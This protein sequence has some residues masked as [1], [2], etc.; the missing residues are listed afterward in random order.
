MMHPFFFATVAVATDLAV[1]WSDC[2]DSSFKAKINDV[3]PKTITMGGTSTITG[4]GTLGEEVTDQVNFDM[5]MEV[6]FEDCKGVA[7]T[8]G[9]CNFPLNM[10]SIEFVGLASPIKA[11]E[12]PINVNLYISR[13]LPA[14]LMETTTQVTA[15][16]K[17][18]GNKIFCLNVY[19]KKSAKSHLGVGILDVT[20]SDCGDADTKS[21]VHSLTPPELK[22][23]ATQHIVG[24]G[25]LSED[26]NE[27]VN[28]ELSQRVKFL[29]CAGDAATSK[30][31]NFPLDLGSMAFKGIQSPIAAGAVSI[32]VDV[33]MSKLIPAGVAVTT[34]HVTAQTAGGDNLFCLDVNTAA[35]ADSNM[36]V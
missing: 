12:V 1:T 6:Q 4:S 14:T 10:G 9:K 34:T 21:V 5:A 35:A 31:C 28:F 36:V 11:G 13:L 25:T 2:G 30:K 19:T 3:E 24:T 23:G 8:G 32:D 26:V 7:S 15:L 33:S 22:Q 17:D 27:D 20:W 18:S 29:N 16:G